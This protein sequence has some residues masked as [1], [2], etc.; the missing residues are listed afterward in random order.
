MPGMRRRDFVALLG[1]AAATWP[2]AARAQQAGKVPTIGILGPTT[3]AGQPQWTTVFCSG[4]ANSAGLKVALSRSNIAGLRDARSALPR[5]LPSSSGSRSTSLS[6][7]NRLHHCSKAG[8][9]GDP[10]RLRGEGD[11]VGT[12][13]VSSLARPGG[14]V[15]GLSSSRPILPEAT[16]AVA[17]GR[18][19]S[20]PSG[21]LG[22][23]WQSR[24]FAGD[25]RG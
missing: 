23:C 4:C 2:L 7:G 5:S 1:G 22:Q 15:T 25:A 17:R 3:L 12:G 24:H 20:P 11:P 8:D 16:R 19:W 14:N 21:D 18:S 9:V 10:N 6:R 13:L